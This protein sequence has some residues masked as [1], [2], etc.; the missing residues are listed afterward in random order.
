MHSPNVFMGNPG[1]VILSATV[2]GGLANLINPDAAWTVLHHLLGGSMLF[3]A[4]FIATDPVSSP[5]T[6]KGKFIFRPRRWRAHHAAAAIQR[7]SGGRHVC[8]AC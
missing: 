4:F 3:G 1:G 7:L 6:P 8:R 5:M 2:F